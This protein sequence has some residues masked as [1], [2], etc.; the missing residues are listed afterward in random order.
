[1][2]DNL[3]VQLRALVPTLAAEL[4]SL[5]EKIPQLEEE[6][7]QAERAPYS[8]DLSAQRGSE[9][10]LD[11]HQEKIACVEALRSAIDDLILA[12]EG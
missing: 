2:T 5:R 6:L 7:C 4:K 9:E 3:P 12:W 1:M 10:R 11:R 8:R